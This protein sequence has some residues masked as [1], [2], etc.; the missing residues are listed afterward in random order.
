MTIRSMLVLVCGWLLAGACQRPQPAV[1]SSSPNA[2]PAVEYFTVDPATA[3][4]IEGTV[5]WSGPRPPARRI[6]MDAEQACQELHP[7]GMRLSPVETGPAGGLAAA[8]IYVKQ[9]LEG[10]RFRPPAEAVVLEQKGCQF[11]PRVLALTVGQ[12]LRVRN[13]DP[14]SHNVHP[15]PQ[16]NRDWN[17]Q[18]PPGAPDIERRFGFP[19]IMIPIRCN[20]HSWMRSYV[21]VTGHPFVT[22]TRPDGRFRLT[23]LPPGDYVIG[24][25]HE[26][27]GE[28]QQ[29][30]TLAPAAK[31]YLDWKLH[32]HRSR[33]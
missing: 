29:R 25:W 17:Q 6:T 2:T 7:N 32:A 20:V 18:Q 8:V 3:A 19:E 30:V 21:A 4:A 23:G 13:S 14:V 27:A 11:V 16:N 33:S 10:K 26:A 15:T 12:T 24:V 5:R 22:V 31:E 28:Q 1:T 9:G